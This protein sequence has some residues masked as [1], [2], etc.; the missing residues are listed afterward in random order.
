MAS[1]PIAI[2]DACVLFPEWLRDLLLRCAEAGLFQVR[3]S[4]EILDEVARNLERD[5]GLTAAQTARLVAAMQRAFPD[6]KVDGYH[7]HIRVLQNDPKDRHV[8]AA[9]LETRGEELQ[10]SIVT[11]NLKDFVPLPEHVRAISADDFL[12][13]LFESSR[14]IVIDL[15]W[16]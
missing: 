2:L 10:V 6:A 7:R 14:A 13:E 1:Q 11:S 5:R 8:V 16:A 15:L 9:A 4:D 12:L 3:W